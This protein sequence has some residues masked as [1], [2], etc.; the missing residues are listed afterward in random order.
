MRRAPSDVLRSVGRRIAELRRDHGLTQEQLGARLQVSEQ[1]LRR[2]ELGVQNV[3]LRT[4]ANVAN[5]LRV[6]VGA[7]FEAPR[8]ASRAV[9]K[10]RP[11]KTP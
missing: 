6:D 5:A 8:P 1:Y 2:I 7:L 3:T 10:G 9:R 4:L 11:R